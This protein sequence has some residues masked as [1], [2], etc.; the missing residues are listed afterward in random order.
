MQILLF[1]AGQRKQRLKICAFLRTF[2]HGYHYKGSAHRDS[3]YGIN[4]ETLEVCCGS[5]DDLETQYS[6]IEKKV[7]NILP[8]FLK[9]PVDIQKKLVE[10]SISKSP[11]PFIDNVFADVSKGGMYWDGVSSAAEYN[12][13]MTAITENLDFNIKNN[14]I[15]NKFSNNETE[16]QNEENPLR[17]NSGKS[18]GGIRCREYKP[19]V[20]IKPL[21]YKKIFGRG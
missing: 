11:I 1:K 5:M 3:Y 2:G 9:L 17:G 18:K 19:R 12:E 21:S 16:L 7:Y 20:T 13:L 14:Y 6:A 8:T 4:T 15:N 10:N